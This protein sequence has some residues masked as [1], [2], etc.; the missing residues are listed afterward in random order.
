[1]LEEV[2]ASG[3]SLII[4]K[5]CVVNITEA[6]SIKFL[7]VLRKQVIKKLNIKV[8]SG[9]KVRAAVIEVRDALLS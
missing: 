8:A 6:F 7:S 3:K 1:M 2:I 9:Q 5:L 4:N